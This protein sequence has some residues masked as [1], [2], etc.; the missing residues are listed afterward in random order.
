MEVKEF[1][2]SNNL[3]ILNNYRYLGFNKRTPYIQLV[4]KINLYFYDKDSI[5]RE[6]RNI[7][8]GWINMYNPY[9]ELGGI[10]R[11]HKIRLSQ[12]GLDNMD[13]TLSYI[14]DNIPS[15]KDNNRNINKYFRIPD[16]YD[17]LGSYKV[18][19]KKEK[20]GFIHKFLKKDQN[21][22]IFGFTAVIVDKKDQKVLFQKNYFVKINSRGSWRYDNLEDIIIDT[23]KIDRTIADLFRHIMYAH[24]DLDFYNIA[25]EQFYKIDVYCSTEFKYPNDAEKPTFYW[26]QL[27]YVNSRYLEKQVKR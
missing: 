23:N 17:Y 16:N 27:N 13:N 12:E 15:H 5:K 9:V 24:S 2:I 25:L 21:N 11:Y 19:K 3:Y 4:K 7:V 6:S 26:R 1:N 14:K 18:E 10:L 8:L 22:I 20:I